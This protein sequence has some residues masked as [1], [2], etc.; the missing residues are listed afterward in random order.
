MEVEMRSIDR[1]ILIVLA[2]GIWA[3]V[4]KPTVL[5]AHHGGADHSCD[6]S[7][8]GYGEADGGEVYVHTLNISVECSH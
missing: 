1:V 2:L 8:D 7:G 5:A 4:L 6:A 3:L